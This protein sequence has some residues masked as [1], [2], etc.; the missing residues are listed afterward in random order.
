MNKIIALKNRYTR[1]VFEAAGYQII[2]IPHFTNAG[3]GMKSR[4]NR[5]LVT[6]SKA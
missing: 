4:N 1:E 3:I 2:I 5:I 6:L